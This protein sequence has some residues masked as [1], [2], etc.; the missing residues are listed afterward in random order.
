MQPGRTAIFLSRLV[1]TVRFFL[2]NYTFAAHKI[3]PVIH[4]RRP[5]ETKQKNAANQQKWLAAVLSDVPGQIRTA[6]LSLRRSTPKG[7][8]ATF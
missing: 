6:G 2:A 7:Q 5:G 4:E 8:S 1:K 3:L